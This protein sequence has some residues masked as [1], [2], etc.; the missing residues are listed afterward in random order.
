MN[1][2]K[3][4]ALFW[5]A[6][7]L[8]FLS[9]GLAMLVDLPSGWLAYI[10]W[11]AFWTGVAWYHRRLMCWLCGHNPKITLRGGIWGDLARCVDCDRIYYL[12]R[13]DGND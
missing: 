7:V 1:R 6:V 5:T 8:L 2:S 9:T 4:I 3:K 11:L 10:A 12:N 13:S